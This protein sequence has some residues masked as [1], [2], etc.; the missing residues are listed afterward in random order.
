MN[1]IADPGVI[2]LIQAWPHTFLEIDHEIY[3]KVVLLSLWS[4]VA[5]LVEHWTG[6]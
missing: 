5:R 3:S 6:D 1:L 4:A 2:S